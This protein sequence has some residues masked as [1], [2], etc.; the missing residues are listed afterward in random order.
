MAM[1][2]YLNDKLVTDEK[3]VVSVFDHGFLYGDGIY[4][5]IRVYEGVPFMLDDHIDRLH[6]SSSLIGLRIP[7]DT[8]AIKAALNE[9]IQ[10]NSL[11]EASLR[12]TVSRGSGPLGLDPGL[13]KMPTF[14]IIPV[15]F[16]KYPATFYSEGVGLIIPRT[17]RNLKEA[18]D[19]RIKSLNFLNN[20]M[21]KM[22]AVRAGAHEALM[23]NHEGS[24]TEC[25]VS[26]IFFIR[27][28][29]IFTPSVECGIL[30]GITRDLTI[31]LARRTCVDVKEGSFTKDEIYSADEIFITNTTMEV[32]PV[33]TID[34][35]TFKVGEITKKLMEEY[36]QE[37]KAHIRTFKL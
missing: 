19:P 7:R 33:G 25:T 14:V 10:S 6:R 21:A 4:E 16:K 37:V 31:A 3:A 13:C 32:M 20:I 36:R 15:Q 1:Y 30:E 28:G 35:H 29:A 18:L 17:R 26:N 9:T 2:I 22:E 34:G 8:E 27:K 23:L 24:L 11:L 5:T 12:I